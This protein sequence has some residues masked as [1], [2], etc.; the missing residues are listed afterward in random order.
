MVGWEDRGGGERGRE[1]EEWTL[2]HYCSV[3]G[4]RWAMC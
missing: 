2:L 1:E 3:I 4:G